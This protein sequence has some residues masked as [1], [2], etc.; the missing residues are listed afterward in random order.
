MCGLGNQAIL[1][2]LQ[3]PDEANG[4]K[5]ENTNMKLQA[6]IS[7]GLLMIATVLIMAQDSLENQDKNFQMLFVQNAKGASVV[8]GKLRL[9]GVGPTTLFFADRPK[10]IAG[11]FVTNEMIELWSEAKDSFTKNPLE[12]TLSSFTSDDKVVNVVLQL[13]N[14]QLAGGTMIYDVRV[15]QGTMPDNVAACSLFIS[16]AGMPLTQFTHADFARQP[17]RRAIIF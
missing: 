8:N 3:L 9:K 4:Q 5:G 13:K 1:Q 15:L 7:V 17:A 2:L 6:L 10:R 11:H 12:A 14:P 16:I